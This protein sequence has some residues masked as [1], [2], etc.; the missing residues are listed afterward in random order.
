MKFVKVLERLSNACGVAGREDEV[1]VLMKD[2]LKPNVD[3]VQE[4][5]LGNVIGVRRGMND[6]PKVMVAAHMDE[7]GL[8]VKNVTAEG[9]VQFVK[10][11]G[12]DDRIL[13]AQKVII[14]TAN[15]P[16]TGIIGSKP[17]H[18][19]KAEEKKKVIEAEALFIDVGA[20]SNKEAVKMG[21]RVGDTVSFDIN[22]TRIGDDVVVGKAF[23]DRVGCAVLATVMERL[24]DVDCT[25][26][27][28]GTI[29]E[30]V[31]L[32]GAATAA[33]SLFPDVGIALDATVAG[34]VP[35]VKEVET[36]IKMRRGPAITVADRGLIT[37]PRVLQLLVDAAEKNRIPY[38]LEAGLPGSTDAARIALTR[39]GV[40]SG[41][42]SIPTRYIHSPISM[43]SLDDAENAAKLAVA[44]IKN[45]SQS[46]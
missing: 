13:I 25:I 44:A 37:H 5:R 24:S 12:I 46:F 42:I 3:E 22:F 21:I 35:G 39:E 29:Q 30:E 27:A 11:G 8:M 38:Q 14:H 15:R 43:L 36:S 17:P 6:S 41:V 28:V 19:L 18:I 7:I 33:F 1:R 34:G 26:Y 31:G 16:L 2:L 20:S 10:I 23:D 40:P 45:V 9:F 32:R 4:D